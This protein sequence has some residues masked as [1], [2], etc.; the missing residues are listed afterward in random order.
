MN[1]TLNK[2][3]RMRSKTK[4]GKWIMWKVAMVW[5][6]M[7]IIPGF[8]NAQALS[9]RIN[10]EIQSLN[11]L[12]PLKDVNAVKEFYTSLEN[13]FAW[14]GDRNKGHR[15]YLFS[16]IR[17]AAYFGLDKKDYQYQQLSQWEISSADTVLSLD[18]LITDAANHFFRDIAFG[19]VVPQ[20]GYRGIDYV[21]GCISV[22]WQLA[23][24]LQYDELDRLTYR[25]QPAMEEIRQ[26]QTL[27]R[28]FNSRI[29]D[30]NFNEETIVSTKVNSSNKPLIRKL[31]NLGLLDSLN[32]RL[33]DSI[34]I[35]KLKRAQQMF[36]VLADG[37]LRSTSLAELNVPLQ[38]RIR[39]LN[40]SINYYRWVYCL[41]RQSPVVVV[42]IPAAFVRVYDG[43]HCLVDM[44]AIVGKPSTPTPTL[45]SRINE[46]ILYPYWMVPHSIATKEL[47]PSIKRNPG[48]LE[49]NGFQV[50]DKKTG[51]LM[52]PASINWSALSVSYFPYIIRQS[53]GCDNALGLLKLNFYNPFSVYLHDTPT[54]SLFMLNKRFFSHGCM[55]LEKPFELGQFILKENTI[56]IDTLTEKGCLRSQAPITVPVSE[57]LP[58]IV[59][60]NPAGLDETGHLT[61]Y[62]DIYHKFD[63]MKK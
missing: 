53:T 3:R 59:W 9:N 19:N 55:R 5:F 48:Y 6:M 7:L 62:S 51:S 44:R 2:T 26:I 30:S 1:C 13:Q 20:V 63:W 42:N 57:P 14:T 22:P 41:S 12:Q 39:Q 61:L 18:I 50:L 40:L 31:Y 23:K 34:L 47:L 21:P 56:A 35:Q 32:G 33:T 17:N 54:K 58:V 36:N 10:D 24:H 29:V 46:V 45:L 4:R 38:A 15:D 43:G 28:R 37:K 11:A 49:D 52:N 60:Y 25:L 27:L 16:L 8:S